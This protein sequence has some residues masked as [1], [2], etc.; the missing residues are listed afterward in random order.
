MSQSCGQLSY[1]GG[2]LGAGGTPGDRIIAIWH[3]P[4]TLGD[5]LTGSCLGKV[6]VASLRASEEVCCGYKP[7]I[8][9]QTEKTMV[10]FPCRQFSNIHYKD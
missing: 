9:H 4:E 7:K 3:A 10:K 8:R 6:P 1:S 5:S 2:A